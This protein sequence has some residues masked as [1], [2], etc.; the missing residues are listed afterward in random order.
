[1]FERKGDTAARN[2]CRKCLRCDSVWD[3]VERS[4]KAPP[5]QEL[6]EWD[7][8]ISKPT[9]ALTAA[10]PFSRFAMTSTLAPT[11]AQAG[12]RQ[13]LSFFLTP[14][15]YHRVSSWVPKQ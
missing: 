13:H 14:A 9:Y 4:Y 11:D 7:V 2:P 1:M 10:V 8:E 6:R 12:G 5:E 15:S 3:P